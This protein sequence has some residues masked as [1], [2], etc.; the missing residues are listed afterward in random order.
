VPYTYI[1]FPRQKTFL[2]LPVAV[3]AGFSTPVTLTFKRLYKL[4]DY[5]GNNQDKNGATDTIY[6]RRF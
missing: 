3:Q 1:V 4:H 2:A 5:V 6:F